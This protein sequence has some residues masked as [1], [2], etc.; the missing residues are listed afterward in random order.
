[1]TTA[2]IQERSLRTC[3][4]WSPNSSISGASP[5]EYSGFGGIGDPVSRATCSKNGH[6]TGVSIFQFTGGDWKPSR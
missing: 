1:L 5:A 4:G 6:F 2:S 3:P